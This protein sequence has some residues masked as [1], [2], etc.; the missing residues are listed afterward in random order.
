MIDY[1]N[2]RKQRTRVNNCFN[3][4][5]NLIYG[6]PQGSMFL[7]SSSFKIA[8]YADDCSPYEFSGSIDDVISKLENDSVTL[9]TWYESNYLQSNPDKWHLLLNVARE[10]LTVSVGNKCIPNTSCEK[11]LG[12]Y[13][14]NKLNFE[15]HVTKLCKKAGKKLHALAR[16]SNYI[17]I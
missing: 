7:F 1:L 3:S 15:M 9:I 11:I 10:D 17:G 6:V 4:W 14:D 8:N 12:I 2:D 16:V 5:R 13:F